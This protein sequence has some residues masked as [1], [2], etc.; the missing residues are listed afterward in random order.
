MT[1]T[2]IASRTTRRAT[3][4]PLG[5]TLR[6]NELLRFIRCYSADKGG[7]SPTFD[8]MK[9]HLGLS[10]KSGISRMVAAMEER[11]VIRRLKNRARAI[12]VVEVAHA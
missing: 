11:G 4:Q 12:V 1:A 3:R 6:Q 9:D 2:R 5:L 8:E 7:V 10:S